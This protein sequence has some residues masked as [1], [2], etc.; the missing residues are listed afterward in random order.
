MLRHGQ[1][2]TPS[3]PG[4]ERA[5]ES[6]AAL[7]EALWSGPVGIALLDPELRFV[8]VNDALAAMTELASEAHVGRTLGD[9]FPVPDD[10]RREVAARAR[11]ALQAVMESRRPQ[12]NVPLSAALPDGTPRG[13][14][15]SFLPVLSED[16]HVEGVCA[17]V[18]DATD[19]YVRQSEVAHARD[20]A[21]E[22]ARRLALLQE[23]TAGLSS[24][25]DAGEIARVVVE[26]VR[27][28]AAAMGT[29]FWRLE[30][31]ALELVDEAGVPA[32]R[33]RFARIR[34]TDALPAAEAVRRREPVWLHSAQEFARFPDAAAVTSLLG[35]LAGAVVPLVGHGR[36]LGVFA[37]VFAEPRAFDAEERAFF[38]SVAEQCA[39]ALE[40]AQ[41]LDAERAQRAAAQRA[42]DRVARL[43]AITAALSRASTAEEVAAVLVDEAMAALKGSSCAVFMLRADDGQLHLAAAMGEADRERERLGTLPLDVPIPV[44]VAAR[45]GMP[46]WLET[47]E[48][49][50]ASFPE[51]PRFAP[52]TAH[53]G[54]LAALPLTVGDCV[55]GAVTFGFD[56]PRAFSTEK[57]EL[58]TAIAQQ[59]AQAL[60]R[61]RLLDVER[62]AR[63]SEARVRAVLDAIFDNA[64]IGIGLIDPDLRF[65]RV[66]PRLAE[67]NGIPAEAHVGRTPR[68]I[69]PELPHDEVEAAFR[70]VLRTGLPKLDVVLSGETPAAPGR[71]RHW[72]ESWYP[73]R[74]EGEISGLGIL[75]R[76]VTAEREAQEFQRNV[77]GIVGHDLRNPLSA[78]T[79][80]AQLLLR[81][82]GDHAAAQ[83]LGERILSNADRMQRIIAVLVDYTRVRGGTG[84][85]LRRQRCDLGAVCR[86]V[87]EECEASHPGRV[88]RTSGPDVHGELDPDRVGQIVANLL[89]NALDYSPPESAVEVAWR[90]DAARA[91]VQV[92]NEGAPIPQEILPVLFEPFRRGERDRPG[93]KDGLGLG[94]FIARSIAT[95]HGGTLEVRSA[96]GERTVFTLTLPLR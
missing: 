50:A 88:V 83:R 22:A 74:F 35:A 64:P 45:S 20:R 29:V 79:T 57:R 52:Y 11:D 62:D 92:A 8:R 51:L 14:L 90:A 65:A 3:Q 73:V 55:L 80:S 69:L 33:R 77:L 18:T 17:L 76:E 71:L 84:I 72:L 41:L 67:I 2:M 89:S 87:V 75:V 25:N 49:F 59:C 48:Q 91:V 12:T 39:Q 81:Q 9:L 28:V 85:P 43:Q 78:V 31:D 46:L 40:R 82:A 53:M 16:G 1:A 44:C 66:N 6:I 30:G 63:A 37:L 24:A 21:E 32:I 54:A 96:P 56:A 5:R 36:V 34:V 26:R 13:W 10:P 60:D 61:A 27:V 38:L 15:C 19:A 93:G 42:G 23:V 68:E 7:L 4:H 70:E 47:H 94:L 95:A 58:M 86:A